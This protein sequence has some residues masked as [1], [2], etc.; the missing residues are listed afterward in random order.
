MLIGVKK[1]Y[2]YD[3]GHTYQCTETG[4]IT[5]VWKKKPFLDYHWDLSDEEIDQKV[6]DIVAHFDGAVSLVKWRTGIDCKNKDTWMCQKLGYKHAVKNNKSDWWICLDPDEF[7]ILKNALNLDEFIRSQ[8]TSKYG[9]FTFGQKIFD[10]R[11]PMESVR[12]ITR[13]MPKNVVMNPGTVKTMIY[14]SFKWG[15]VRKVFNQHLAIPAYGER[16]Y[17]DYSSLMYYHYRGGWIDGCSS[18]E[19]NSVRDR[20]LVCE[21]DTMPL[22]LS[23]HNKTVN[24][25]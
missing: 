12:G 11:K 16:L 2:L 7:L 23:L 24:D 17:V 21:D 5:G 25:Y 9:A 4:E 8:D 13:C 1:F 15:R 20:E 3:N 6:R 22:F 14:N 10:A 18:E 19:F